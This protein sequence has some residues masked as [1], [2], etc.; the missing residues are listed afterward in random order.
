[1]NESL[2]VFTAQNWEAEVLAA[3]GTVLVDFWAAWC[4]PCRKLS[5]LVD[6]LAQEYAGRLKVGKLD[7]DDSPDVASRYGITSIPSLLVF[8]DGQVVGQRVGCLPREE[9][10]G[11]VDIHAD[12]VTT[13]A[14]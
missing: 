10:R 12:A 11:W 3:E 1:M 14:R 8:R 13:A 5:P 7:V 9:L 4:P 2:H 6:E